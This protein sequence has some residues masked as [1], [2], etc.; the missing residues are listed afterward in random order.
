MIN[1][2]MIIDND[3]CNDD[4]DTM[5]VTFINNVTTST[6]REFKRLDRI[7]ARLTISLEMSSLD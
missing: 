6:S 3:T 7:V 2:T 4:N 1:V 5:F